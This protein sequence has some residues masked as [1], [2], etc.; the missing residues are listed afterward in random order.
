VIYDCFIF[1]DELELL[2]LRLMETYAFVDWFVLVECP[3]N[4]QQNEKPLF[5]EENKGRFAQWADKIRHIIAD[6]VP[7]GPFPV[8]EAAQRDY[9][10][11]G[12]ED[13]DFKDTI[14]ISDPD[15]IMSRHALAQ[16]REKPPNQP[17]G[18][19]QRLYYYYV[20]CLQEQPWVG[21]IAM[22]RGLEDISGQEVR[23]SR[24][25]KGAVQT[26]IEGGWHFS[27]MGDVE[28]LQYKL[29]CH[30]IKEDSEAF[31]GNIEPPDPM[32]TGHLEECL[33]TGKDLFRREQDYARKHFVP[34]LPGETHPVTIL[35]W[36]QKYPHLRKT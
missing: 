26:A 7:M 4:W 29:M 21:P 27:W 8:I 2:E 19:V 23:L 25:V 30:T 5:Y 34:V 31:G 15:E 32:D 18:L 10:A 9:M 1:N 20:N 16:L 36:L 13:A 22:P 35:E 24:T 14:I 28:R 3:Y 11:Q 33:A 6:P 12:F 17:I